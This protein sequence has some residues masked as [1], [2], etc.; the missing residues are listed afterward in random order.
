MRP[1]LRDGCDLVPQSAR[2]LFAG[3]QR[4]VGKESKMAIWQMILI[5]LHVVPGVFWAGST[6]ALARDPMM[7]ERS[8]GMAQAG[9]A[10]F[11]ILVGIVLMAMHYDVT[12]GAP[13]VDLS[14]GALCALIAVGVQ[15]AV[16]W[17][18]RRRLAQGI[19]DA[20][21]NRRQA[22]IGQRVA[23]LLLLVT[24]CTMVIWRYM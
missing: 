17:R 23:A 16:G 14:I 22:M 2:A 12:P 18:G 6:F 21:D 20:A 13:M 11:T 24:V 9:A 15:H 10:G 19:G 3:L 5:V 7:G 8:L 1:P 4:N